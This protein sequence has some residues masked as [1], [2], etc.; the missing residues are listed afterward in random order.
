MSQ[1]T[2][3]PVQPNQQQSQGQDEKS[4]SLQDIG[5]AHA[6]VTF[7]GPK[8]NGKNWSKFSF[9]F[10]A[11]LRGVRLN[12]VLDDKNA[13]GDRA[14]LCYSLLAGAVEQDQLDILYDCD[15]PGEA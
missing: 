2:D 1:Q 14:D 15:T 6:A 4:S 8:L 5:P 7:P 12:E 13:N 3:G 9:A 10:R 11:F